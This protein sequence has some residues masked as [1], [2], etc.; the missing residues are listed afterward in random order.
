MAALGTGPVKTGV[1]GLHLIAFSL[2]GC[3]HK[4]E[5]LLI[6]CDHQ[7]QLAHPLLSFSLRFRASAW[8][9]HDPTA[10]YSITP[11][12]RLL[13]PSISVV[14]LTGDVS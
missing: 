11:V 12:Q 1:A 3:L 7:D 4:F 14:G 2:H 13:A 5:D 8:S 6:V 9:L 10:D